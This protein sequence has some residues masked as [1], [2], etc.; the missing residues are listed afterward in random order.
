MIKSLEIRKTHCLRI[1]KTC[2]VDEKIRYEVL[3]SKNLL[4]I[5]KA[6]NKI[7]PTKTR[8]KVEYDFNKI[9]KGSLG[10]LE[11]KKK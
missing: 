7:L 1:M 6:I 8:V 3:N 9:F 11:V 5:E 4:D 10:P 2:R